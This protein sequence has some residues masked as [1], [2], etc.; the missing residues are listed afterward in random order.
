MQKQ[1]ELVILCNTYNHAKY[2]RQAL[3][4]FLMQ[5]TDFEY[6]IYIHDDAS[7]DGTIDILREYQEKEPDKLIIDYEIENQY[8]QGN[9][10]LEKAFNLLNEYKYIAICEGDD[11]WIYPYKLQR[12]YEVLE[13]NKDI[14]M[15]V[16]NGIINNGGEKLKEIA[17]KKI[18]NGIL[19]PNQFISHDNGHFPTS[20]FFCRTECYTEI[21][22]YFKA[23]FDD[24]IMC[25]CGRLGKIYYLDEVWTIYNYQSS[26]EAWSS[27]V[28]QGIDYLKSYTINYVKS[29]DEYDL[30]TKGEFRE[31]VQVWR[32]TILYYLVNILLKGAGNNVQAL[33]KIVEEYKTICKNKYDFELNVIFNYLIVRC[34]DFKQYVLKLK[35]NNQN[36][37]IYIYGAGEEATK[38]LFSLEC[39]KSLLE[40]CVISSAPSKDYFGGYRVWNVKDVLGG[41]Q[42]K[43]FVIALGLRNTYQVMLYLQKLGAGDILLQQLGVELFYE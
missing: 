2:I 21:P 32:I 15:C 13:S 4:G 12:Q 26:D 35:D 5:K 24:Q 40:G 36:R 34:D 31:Q 23:K 30:D 6:T 17:I 20:S 14:V 9:D 29:I 42:D 11:Y 37:K 41:T 25:N 27:C 1:K 39:D 7:T 43:V 28:E 10:F 8:S 38:L 19:K 18:E 3:E 22:K 33:Y 16:H